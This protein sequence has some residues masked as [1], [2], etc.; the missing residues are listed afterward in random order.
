VKDN[1]LLVSG[2]GPL[3]AILGKVQLN[4]YL[5]NWGNF[6]T[7]QNLNLFLVQGLNVRN[8]CTSQLSK[9]SFQ[10]FLNQEH[11]SNAPV[12]ENIKGWDWQSN[13]WLEHH[14]NR[15][16]YHLIKSLDSQTAW[17]CSKVSTGIPAIKTRLV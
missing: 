3:N 1:Y 10:L 5:W 17:A 4:I 16:N 9:E 8:P 7:T 15:K 13:V 12:Q 6:V 2:G 11:K 14:Y